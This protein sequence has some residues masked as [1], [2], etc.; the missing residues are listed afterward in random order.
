MVEHNPEIYN[1][2]F[3]VK[4]KTETHSQI[5]E[6][7]WFWFMPGGQFINTDNFSHVGFLVP[8]RA[9]RLSPKR[10]RKTKICLI[11][12]YLRIKDH[13]FESVFVSF[14]LKP[15]CVGEGIIVA[16][17]DDDVVGKADAEALHVAS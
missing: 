12:K 11:N 1:S 8:G 10:F 7:C 2:N 4:F 5:N 15:S 3:A 13:R 17:A 6:G 16:L 14:R 9:V